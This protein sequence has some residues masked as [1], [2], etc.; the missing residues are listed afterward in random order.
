MYF[1][2]QL[3]LSSYFCLRIIFPLNVC[4]QLI[5]IMNLVCNLLIFWISIQNQLIVQLS[6]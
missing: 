4:R 6:C 3:K 5:V 1:D 2:V